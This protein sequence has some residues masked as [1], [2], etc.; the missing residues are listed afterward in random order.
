MPKIP[1]PLLDEATAL[2][3]SFAI[4]VLTAAVLAGAQWFGTHLP[5]LIQYLGT[6]ATAYGSYKAVS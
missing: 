3:K 5:V 6:F 2:L 1:Q 4:T